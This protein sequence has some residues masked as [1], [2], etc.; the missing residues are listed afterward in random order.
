V[1]VLNTISSMKMLIRSIQFKHRMLSA[2]LFTGLVV[3]LVVGLV[4]S[5]CRAVAP[6]SAGESHAESTSALRIG[7]S[8]DYPPFSDWPI[9]RAEP[10]GFSVEVA[11]IY[12]A[13]RGQRS[14]WARFRW[15]ELSSDLSSSR[16][17]L[18]I[19]GITVR[20]DRSVAGRFSIPLTTSGAIVLVEQTSQIR[21]V[22]DLGRPGLALAVNAGGHLER[23][24][25]TL[26]AQARI[27]AV[28]QNAAV[29]DRLGK[30]GVVAVMTDTLEAPLWQAN[31]P[32]LRAIGPLTNDR[33]AAWFSIEGEAEA[34]RFDD[35]LLH[36]EATGTL[37]ELRRAHGLPDSQTARPTRALLASLDERLSLMVLVA[38]AKRTL[39]I[40][41]EDVMR[42][43][44]VLEAALAGVKRSAAR[45]GVRMPAKDAVRRLYQAQIEA[46]KWI[47]RDWIHAQATQ[48]EVPAAA[49]RSR[50]RF[51]LDERIRPALLF[52]GNR[53]ARL[54][55][56]APSANLTDLRYS[57]V[58][59]ALARHGLPDAQL[60]AIHGALVGVGADL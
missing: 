44:R 60:H 55:V 9:D 22:V 51:D 50:A 1:T 2:I 57:E 29:L 48:P 52:L 59:R 42:E 38:R 47:Q 6:G 37:A 21:T 34:R 33:K 20:P 27:E 43:K 26:F 54:V 24:S 35:W 4:A 46:A 28:E 25:R 23:V 19:S 3:G 30:N 14:E 16:F 8:G 36:A 18:A 39:G 53:I 56:L 58:A 11:R 49:Q 12:A 7:T 15:P 40:E 13:S 31:R 41:I 5:G 17:D 32:G 45:S 10:T